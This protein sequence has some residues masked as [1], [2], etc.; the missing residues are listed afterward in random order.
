MTF[1]TELYAYYYTLLVNL[2]LNKH[3][4]PLYLEVE[5]VEEL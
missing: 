3:I 4:T 5:T 2:K 1:Q